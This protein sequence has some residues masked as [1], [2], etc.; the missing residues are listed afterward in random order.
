MALW[1]W[2]DKAQNGRNQVTRAL[3]PVPL[4]RHHVFASCNASLPGAKHRLSAVSSS[5]SWEL[6]YFLFATGKFPEDHLEW[7]HASFCVNICEFFQVLLQGPPVSL[8]LP[9]N[10]LWMHILTLFTLIC[11]L[12]IS[13][14]FSS[15]ILLLL[16]IIC[17]TKAKI[18]FLP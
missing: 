1:D 5:A 12:L 10:Y 4:D 13:S 7:I 15:E 9:T 18:L 17:R 8:F 11:K 6:S 16:H 14:I 3:Q 2:E